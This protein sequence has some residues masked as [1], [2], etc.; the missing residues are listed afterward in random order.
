MYVCMHVLLRL[1][2]YNTCLI[3]IIWSCNQCIYVYVCMCVLLRLALYN[4]C[5]I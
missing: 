2:L 4:T 3:R 1:A 5:L